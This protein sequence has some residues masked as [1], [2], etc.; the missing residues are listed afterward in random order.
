MDV[1]IQ[2]SPI[3]RQMVI[4]RDN[5]NVEMYTSIIIFWILLKVLINGL[6]A[7]QSSTSKLRTH[8]AR[9]SESVTCDRRLLNEL[10]RLFVTL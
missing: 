9:P 10:K 7:T 1:K 3:G 2:I 6:S 5:V 8:I 4:T